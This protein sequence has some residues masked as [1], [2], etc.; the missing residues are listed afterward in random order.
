MSE[1]R[2]RALVV[3]VRGGARGCAMSALEHLAAAL[4]HLRAAEAIL[5]NPRVYVPLIDDVRRTARQVATCCAVASE[6]ERAQAPPE[7]DE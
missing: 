6:F 5:F 7:R 1:E 3:A 2:E 4:R